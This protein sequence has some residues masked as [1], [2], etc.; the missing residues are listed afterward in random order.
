L[1]G[2]GFKLY[3]GRYIPEE[4]QQ[5]CAYHSPDRF[6]I[7]DREFGKMIHKFLKEYLTSNPLSVKLQDFLT[8]P[9]PRKKP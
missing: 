4:I 9:D 7:V 8:G 2:L 3:V 6:V 5:L 1:N